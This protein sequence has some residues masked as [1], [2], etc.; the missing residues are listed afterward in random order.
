MGDKILHYSL[1]LMQSRIDDLYGHIMD[2]KISGMDRYNTID[3]K[4]QYE[5][6]KELDERTKKIFWGL[7]DRYKYKI[8]TKETDGI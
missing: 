3:I 8:S 5:F 1:D 2:N 7:W 4:N 6:K